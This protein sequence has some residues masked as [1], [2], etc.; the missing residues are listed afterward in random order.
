MYV[1]CTV[2]AKGSRLAKPVM[3][4]G[5]MCLAFLTGLNRVAEYR[6]HWSD[7]IAGFIIGMAIATFLVVCVV[8]NFK[9]KLLLNEESPAEQQ[10]NTAILNMGQVEGSLEKY[11]ASQETDDED[12]ES[13]YIKKCLQAFLRWLQGLN[14]FQHLRNQRQTSYEVVWIMNSDNSLEITAHLS[15][16]P[17]LSVCV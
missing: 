9:G 10:P 2:H 4:L 11:I 5:F 12:E 15:F 17:L 13:C 7:V 6:N 14:W 8:H 16:L 3:S 1:T